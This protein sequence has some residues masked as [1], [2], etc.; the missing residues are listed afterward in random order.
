MYCPYGLLAS[1]PAV[2]G[3]LAHTTVYAALDYFIYAAVDEPG[4]TVAC[5]GG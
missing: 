2:V 1:Q 4:L 3:V 5:P